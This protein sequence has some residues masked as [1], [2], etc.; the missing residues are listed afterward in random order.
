MS[1]SASF[2]KMPRLSGAD[3]NAVRGQ[4]TDGRIEL[5]HGSLQHVGWNSLF[6]L[7]SDEERRRADALVFERDARRF[8]VSHALLRVLLN[9]FTGEPAAQLRLRTER[10][11]KPV[12]ET[13]VGQP[14][15][16]SLSRSEELVMIGFASRPLGVDI[17]WVGRALDIEGLADHV[18]SCRELDAFRGLD[19]GDR[20]KA[21]LRCWTQKEA[22]LKAIGEGLHISPN[23]VEVSLDLAARPG[24]KSISGYWDPLARWFVDIVTPQQ[25]YIGAVAIPGGPWQVRMTRFDT[26][27]LLVT[28]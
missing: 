12:V 15:H 22:Y 11:S 14:I 19:P 8:V 3:G 2:R 18:L 25:G 28:T 4:R 10:G 24:L 26:S 20:Q 6:G 13:A 27:A 16:F 17:E 9:R 21:F 1:L 5:W 23:S 7:L